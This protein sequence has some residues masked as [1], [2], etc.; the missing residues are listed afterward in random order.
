M[1]VIDADGHVEEN[2]AT[3]SDAYLDPAFRAQ[4]PRVIGMD[5]LAYWMIDEQ[6]YPQERKDLSASAKAS[7]LERNALR[8]YNLS[9]HSTLNR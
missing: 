1:R 9:A 4:R 7:I 3:F 5:G 8:L 2:P 6:L